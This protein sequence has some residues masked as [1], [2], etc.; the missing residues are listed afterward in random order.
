MRT[1]LRVNNDEEGK[2]VIAELRAQAK[3]HNLIERAK[4]IL[5]PDYKATFKRIDLFGRLG[6][7][8]PNR[9]KYSVNGKRTIF[10][11]AIRISLKDAAY[12][13]IYCNNIVR[14]K[15]SG[16]KITYQ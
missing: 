3:A 15:Y 6:R 7:N 13:A 14:N 2:K 12:I 16:F 11:K 9:H 4:E 10:Y 1:V 5:D 8:N